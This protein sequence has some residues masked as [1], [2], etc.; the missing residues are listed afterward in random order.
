MSLI[1]CPECG[2]EVSDLAKACPH[3]G[4]RIA[5]PRKKI[6]IT[7]EQK[8]KLLVYGGSTLGVLCLIF[9]IYLFFSPKTFSWCCIH[10]I[11][12]AT[13]VEAKKCS[14]CGKTWDNAKGHNWVDATCIEPRKCLD[15]GL[16]EGEVIDHTWVD[17][18]CTEPKTCTVCGITEGKAKDHKWESSTCLKPR[19]CK[20]CGTTEGEKGSHFWL[21]ADC[22]N[23]RRCKWCNKKDGKAYGHNYV[24]YIC[25]VCGSTQKLTKE[26]VPNIL[27]I[28]SLKYN[29][30]SVGGVDTYM[31]FK[32][33]SSTKTINYVTVT[34]KH[35]NKVGDVIKDE[36]SGRELTGLTFTGPL[37]PGKTSSEI[38][39][40]APFYNST[41]SGTYQMP[42]IL[43]EYS[44]GTSLT[45]NE[46]IAWY[47]VKAWRK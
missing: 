8:K 40:R 4:Y 30:N 25:S 17:A 38:Y 35:L 21:S 33:K 1:N 3:C 20:V 39:W 15:C 18:T 24:D 32:N 14:R 19:T 16:T 7:S 45:L 26:D 42:E 36:V 34:V 47:A 37:K 41:F 13:C 11:C 10:K 6:D 5:K 31:T 22:E 9:F 28:F 43:I 44:D 2:R 12:E 23:P 29:I 27:D 46:D